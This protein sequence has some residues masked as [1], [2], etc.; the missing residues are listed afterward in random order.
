MDEAFKDTEL[1]LEE[2]E[3]RVSFKEDRFVFLA[4]VLMGVLL[5]ILIEYLVVVI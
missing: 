5:T 3:Q 1:A 2:T 4:G